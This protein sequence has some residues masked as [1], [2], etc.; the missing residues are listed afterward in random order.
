MTTNMI[1]TFINILIKDS[2]S[3]LKRIG[4]SLHIYR[5][6]KNDKDAFLTAP[7][8][9]TSNSINRMQDILLEMRHHLNG[10]YGGNKEYLFGRMNYL[11]DLAMT[12]CMNRETE[13]AFV[14][15]SKI[16]VNKKNLIDLRLNKTLKSGIR[17]DKNGRFV[18]KNNRKK[19]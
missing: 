14:S 9:N 8:N 6:M 1:N 15:P 4:T 12:N 13:S 5:Q 2:N 11:I 7:F 3:T 19:K 16:T 18:A 17:R 10:G